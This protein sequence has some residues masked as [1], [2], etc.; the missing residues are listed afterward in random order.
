[1]SFM[2]L[3]LRK[4]LIQRSLGL[5]AKRHS[6]HRQESTDTAYRVQWSKSTL[7]ECFLYCMEHLPVELIICSSLILWQKTKSIYFLKGHWITLITANVRA[8]AP[9]FIKIDV[10][11]DDDK[12]ASPKLRDDKSPAFHNSL[13]HGVTILLSLCFSPSPL[14]SLALHRWYEL[15]GRV[16]F[17]PFCSP[18]IALLGSC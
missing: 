11:G 6:S 13:N 4:N 18:P 17:I 12:I 15:P 5:L 9:V 3:C 8:I 14:L 10:L 1:M 2:C 7:G 16:F